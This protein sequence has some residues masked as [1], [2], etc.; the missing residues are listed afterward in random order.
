[1]FP[2][3]AEDIARLALRSDAFRTI[4]EDHGMAV[5]ALRR[6]ETRN[7]PLD[8]EKIVEYRT[9]IRDLEQELR[10]ALANDVPQPEL[11]ARTG[12]KPA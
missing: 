9:L 10:D 5:E 11:N 2:R 8:L 12:G 3:Q 7:H 4:C 1:M 6:L